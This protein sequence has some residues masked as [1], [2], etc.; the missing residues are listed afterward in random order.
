MLDDRGMETGST[1]HGGEAGWMADNLMDILEKEVEL[2][3]YEI[4]GR[5]AV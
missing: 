5:R 3:L 2:G 1:Y 4:G